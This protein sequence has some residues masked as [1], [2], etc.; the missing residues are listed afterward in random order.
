MSDSLDIPPRI[1]MG[2]GSSNVDPRVLQAMALPS[3]GHLAPDSIRVMDS[4]KAMLRRASVVCGG[5]DR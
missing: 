2:P 4:V 1:L 5:P 3:I